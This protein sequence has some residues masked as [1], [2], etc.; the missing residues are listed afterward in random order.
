MHLLA[1]R[2]PRRMTAATLAIVVAAL[3]VA[4]IFARTG[5]AASARPAYVDRDS[6]GGSCSDER[7]YEEARSPAAPW[8]SLERAVAAAPAGAE[9]AIRAGE[10]PPLVIRGGRTRPDYLTLRAHP[11]ERPSTS[12]T[13]KKTSYLHVEGLRLRSVWLTDAHHV[14][15]RSNEITPSGVVVRAGSFLEFEQNNFHDIALSANQTQVGYAIRLVS[16]PNADVRI[17]GNK[18]DRIT[19]DAIQAGSTDRILIEGNEIARCNAWDDPTEHSDGIQF[20][21]TVTDAIVRR[22]WLHHN[23]HSMIAKGHTYAG[24]IIENNLIHDT[25]SGLNL[26]DTPGAQIIN[27]TIWDVGDFGLRLSQIRGNMGGV[28]V[29]NNIIQKSWATQ[30]YMAVDASNQIDGDPMFLDGYELS[31]TSRAVDAGN[32]A[33]S[34]AADR[35]G[36]DRGAPD[37]GAHERQVGSSAGG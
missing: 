31:A 2:P 33:Y 8:C 36:R 37:V 29:A 5:D 19:S 30:R 34:P 28:V 17:V 20:Y 9:V 21:G 13:L 32:A 23:N 35:L 7:S 27:N 25:A 14:R 10:Y 4:I 18:F 12:L 16:G 11:G 24:L 6:L 3:A 22:N 1:C 26:Y 15:L